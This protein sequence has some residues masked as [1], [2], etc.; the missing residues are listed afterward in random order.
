MTQCEAS[1]T[2]DGHRPAVR[3]SC[4]PSCV[5]GR[6]MLVVAKTVGGEHHSRV[7]QTAGQCRKRG[8]ATV[9]VLMRANQCRSVDRL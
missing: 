2:W 3:K 5:Q 1:A 9:R 7:L 4:N 6:G 8:F